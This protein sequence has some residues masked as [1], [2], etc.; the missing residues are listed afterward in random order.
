MQVEVTTPEEHMG[1]VIGDLNSR[2]GLV[3]E[4]LDKPGNQR[5]STAALLAD[6]DDY[7][8]A[9]DL[10]LCLAPQSAPRLSSVIQQQAVKEGH[11]A[12]EQ[13]VSCSVSGYAK[14]APKGAD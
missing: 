11:A 12:E 7:L 2:R 13:A 14:L 3:G 9:Y 5:V 1:D 6:P 8:L 4:F 10:S